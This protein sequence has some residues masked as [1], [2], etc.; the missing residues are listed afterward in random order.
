[1]AEVSPIHSKLSSAFKPA[2]NLCIG[3]RAESCRKLLRAEELEQRGG[4]VAGARGELRHTVGARHEPRGAI[5]EQFR[6]VRLGTGTTQGRRRDVE[7]CTRPAQDDRRGGQG[8]NRTR[9]A[10]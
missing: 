9:E 3:S 1:M 7:A 10:V 6:S 5:G 2:S 8:A 4:R